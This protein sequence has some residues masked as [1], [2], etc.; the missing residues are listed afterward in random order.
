MRKVAS[1]VKC[2]SVVCSKLRWYRKKVGGKS[3][4]SS[5]TTLGN[6]N[7]EVNEIIE[8]VVEALCWWW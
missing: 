7:A 5:G 1:C 2:T 8:K 6:G 3:N 4:G